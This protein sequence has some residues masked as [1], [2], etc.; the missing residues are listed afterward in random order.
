[1]HMSVESIILEFERAK[2]FHPTLRSEMKI[3][4]SRFDLAGVASPKFGGV[5]IKTVML[6][7]FLE[8]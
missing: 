3:S 8:N 2:S 4:S 1:M 6:R 5:T 7:R